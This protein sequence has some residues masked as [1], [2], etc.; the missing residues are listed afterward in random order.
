MGTLLIRMLLLGS[1]S[2]A[3]C[4]TNSYLSKYDS[5]PDDKTVRFHLTDGEQIKSP[6]GRHQRVEGG[7]Q[8]VGEF[9]KGMEIREKFE[10]IVLDRMIDYVTVQ[11]FN[12]AGTVALVVGVSAVIAVVVSLK[13]F[14]LA[15]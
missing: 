2:L 14:A 12:T 5:L 13:G 1:L 7:Y 11:E 3:G 6:S 10:G 8:V 15:W 4:Y 9:V